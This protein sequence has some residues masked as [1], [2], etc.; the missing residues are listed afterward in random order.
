MADQVW[1]GNT[2]QD[3]DTSTNWDGA[4]VPTSSDAVTIDGNSTTPIVGAGT[5]AHAASVVIEKTGGPD[6][7]NLAVLGSGAVLTVEGDVTATRNNGQSAEELEVANQG[8]LNVG[9]NLKL[10]NGADLLVDQGA[11]NVTGT[12]E[13]DGQASIALTDSGSSFRAAAITGTG[14]PASP[15]V[16]AVDSGVDVTLNVGSLTG[17]LGLE[18]ESG[19]RLDFNAPG[20]ASYF[21]ITG[22]SVIDGILNI[23]D[24]NT[25]HV[26][27]GNISGSG[28]IV[29]GHT[30]ELE[31]DTTGVTTFEGQIG[32]DN[33]NG[34]SPS[35]NGTTKLIVSGGGELRLNNVQQYTGGTVVG[36]GTTLSLFGLNSGDISKSSGLDLSASGAKFDISGL[37]GG[38][39]TIQNLTGVAGTSV[40]LGNNNLDVDLAS[41]TSE[42][43]G[44]VTG[45]ASSSLALEGP[46][47]LILSGD[48]S[49]ALGTLYVSD[50]T[51]ALK[52]K[53]GGDVGVYSVLDLYENAK[54]AGA[55]TVL[56]DPDVSLNVRGESTVGSLN[57]VGANLNFFV[58]G[59][60]TPSTLLHVT[61]AADISDATVK[62]GLVGSNSLDV[63]QSLKLI[64]AGGGIDADGAT[65]IG[66]ATGLAGVSTTY[67]F[68]LGIDPV[69][70][71]LV[72]TVTAKGLDEKTKALSE[73]FLAGVS[74][75][76][77]GGDLVQDKGIAQA[78]DST[79]N[80]AGL[81]GFGAVGGG[82]VRHE[83]G[84]HVDVEG[85][86]LVAGLALG[87]D[88]G[89][90]KLT[91]GAFFEYGDGDYDSYNSFSSSGRVHGRGDTEYAGG[92]ALARF[93]FAEGQSG[94]PYV[95]GTV[96]AGRVKSDFSSKDLVDGFGRSAKYDSKSGY[97]GFSLGG[98]YILKFSQENKLDLYG[99][100]TFTEQ[101]N[102]KVRLSTGERVKFDDVDSSRLRLGARFSAA[103]NDSTRAYVGAAYER[104]FDGKAKASIDGLDVEAPK[105]RGNSG[106]GEIGVSFSPA[107]LKALS[108][109]V[110]VQGYAGKREG[111]TGSVQLKY[112]F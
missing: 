109:D 19:A 95:D 59:T 88:V 21:S 106:V 63:G 47:T 49:S 56:A 76:N 36:A 11:V 67:E 94:H 105:L 78:L 33:D 39:T 70:G 14:S 111:V 18:I 112:A 51:V 52:N 91:A 85:Y 48:S 75:I 68:N 4:A 100:Y 32:F 99:R 54:V 41:G 64:E 22:N 53:W 58:P 107:A 50:G 66:K 16:I 40:I 29:T 83:S 86:N 87:A 71:A 7:A 15:N 44:T 8:T 27:L 97:Y 60:N 6:D 82:K 62:V 30:D 77:Q 79:R 108:L 96:R 38:T 104:E 43:A 24:V 55:V 1:E 9:G 84:S 25:T 34:G 2:N 61:G 90:G 23:E 10:Q 98:G 101:G 13:L 5:D 46:G 42:F 69:T 93:D 35:G 65:Y 81:Q 17:N 26:K 45:S 80:A 28:S 72:S 37:G 20:A 73:G 110:A 3:W 103:L 89:V 12:V 102:D 31:L 92:G 57:A 74:F